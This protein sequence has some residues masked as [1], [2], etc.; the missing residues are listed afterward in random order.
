MRHFAKSLWWVDG[1]KW[2][3]VPGLRRWTEVLKVDQ[4]NR[5][6]LH[7]R[8]GSQGLQQTSITNNSILQWSEADKAVWL[9][10]TPWSISIRQHEGEVNSSGIVSLCYLKVSIIGFQ[11]SIIAQGGSNHGT[12]AVH[13]LFSCDALL[14][15]W[16]NCD[17]LTI[18]STQY[19]PI[20]SGACSY[21]NLT[22]K[23]NVNW[24]FAWI[25]ACCHILT[26]FTNTYIAQGKC[27]V[28][29]SH[30]LEDFELRK[31]R[32]GTEICHMHPWLV[33]M[34]EYFVP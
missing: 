22:T 7:Q 21:L 1:C 27:F 14:L 17:L 4:P 18:C 12:Q 3:R 26:P 24:R 19:Q 30:A 16:A 31:W 9:I 15:K 28:G 29:G 8:S 25:L 10:K 2:C 6:S 34:K 23:P 20:K 33:L 13:P 32:S 11:P 5:C